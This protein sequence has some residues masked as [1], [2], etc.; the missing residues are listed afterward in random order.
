MPIA[1]E[2]VDTRKAGTK[3]RDK[4]FL[5]T[6]IAI[7]GIGQSMLFVLFGPLARE[8]GLSEI[9][10]GLLFTLSNIGLVFAAPF[11]GRKSDSV[12]RKPIFIVGL[13]GTAAG[14]LALGLAIQ[15]GLWHILPLWGL[16][17]LLLAARFV[18]SL[19]ATAVYPASGAYMA[20]ITSREDR[21]QG[22]ALIGG[23]NSLGA[24]LGPAIGG[25]LAFIHILFPMYA[26]GALALAGAVLAMYFLVEPERSADAMRPSTL[27]F[28]D[29]RLFPF[30]ILWSLFFIVFTT[31]Q[32]ITAFYIQDRFGI[33][34]P[35][36]VVKVAALAMVAMGGT[37]VVV[38]MGLLQVIR[39]SPKTSLRL[40]FP[41]VA[42]GLLLLAFA[43]TL[44]LI[45]PAYM[46]MGLAF[47]MANPGISG[48]G[49]LSV[50]P[51][52]QGTASGYLSAATTSGVIF[53]PLI[54]TSL[55]QIIPAMPLFFGAGLAICAGIYAF[56]VHIP[57][58]KPT[59]G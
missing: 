41:F 57:D 23:A 35:K 19:T 25:G 18:Y 59:P 42:T 28:T 51:H 3:K 39:I 2:K 49:S 5:F 22:M 43:P 53:G 9:Q 17:L 16:F 45:F 29:R 11:W 58:T 56:F 50:E 7:F 6:G 52:E 24:I 30:I 55:Y 10:F 48:G 1:G 46:C 4:A 27:K 31:L 26:A 32:F 14:M 38:Q 40:C 20:D 36:E 34:E 54:G 15:V 13:L 12:G 8:M 21:A 47:S 37:N 33:T 44:S